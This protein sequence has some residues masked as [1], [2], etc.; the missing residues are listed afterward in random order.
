MYGFDGYSA[1]RFQGLSREALQK[2]PA[3]FFEAP[4]KPKPLGKIP[5]GT[6][7]MPQEAGI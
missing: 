1:F 6:P 5:Y 7:Y 4:Q 3:G 2:G